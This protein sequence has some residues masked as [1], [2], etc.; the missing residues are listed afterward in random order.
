MKEPW[1]ARVHIICICFVVILCCPPLGN[2]FIILQEAW[3]AMLDL[4][5]LPCLALCLVT[6]LRARRCLFILKNDT[7]LKQ[8]R[9]IVLEAVKLF[10]IDLPVTNEILCIRTW[11]YAC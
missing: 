10:V 9:R 7:G 8:R 6:G 1:Y 3:N 5:C 2:R 4:T 11:E